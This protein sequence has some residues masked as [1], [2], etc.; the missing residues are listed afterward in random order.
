[1][2]VLVK[3]LQKN[4]KI[5]EKELTAVISFIMADLGIGGK[6]ICFVFMNNQA[7]SKLNKKYFGRKSPTDVISFNL[8][9]RIDPS[10]T[11]GEVF[12]SVEQALINADKFGVRVQSELVR[13]I[14]HGLLHILGYDD[15]NAVYKKKMKIKEEALLKKTENKF[16]GGSKI[17]FTRNKNKLNL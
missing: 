6:Q 3:D 1:M 13:Y 5:K 16:T 7:I 8:D 10:K 11:M 14:I 15:L 17:F 2:G 12:I 9:D 4:L